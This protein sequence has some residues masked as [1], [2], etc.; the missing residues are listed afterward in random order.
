MAR[1]FDDD[2]IKLLLKKTLLV[3]PCILSSSCS[4]DE[5]DCFPPP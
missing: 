2:G 1:E 3:T 4:M 5:E